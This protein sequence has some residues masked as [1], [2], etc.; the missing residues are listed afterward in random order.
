VGIALPAIAADQFTAEIDNAGTD[1]KADN[2][3]AEVY[4]EIRP[5][6]GQQRNSWGWRHG[7]RADEN[8]IS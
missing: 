5:R 6:V 2:Q 7:N 1:Q 8:A 3:Q 4:S